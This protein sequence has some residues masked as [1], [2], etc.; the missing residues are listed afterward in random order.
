MV[1]DSS[2][3]LTTAAAVT[4]IG[5]AVATIQHIYMNFKRK[6][7]HYRQSIVDQAKNE[8]DLM[9]QSLEIKINN[10]EAELESQKESVAKD[11]GFLKETYSNEIKGL[12]EKIENLRSD[13]STQHAGLVALLTRL[14]DSR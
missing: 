13:L 4:A 5:G 1:I 10:L 8:L 11:L 3:I 6:R 2:T 14:V 12:A 9:R 7:E